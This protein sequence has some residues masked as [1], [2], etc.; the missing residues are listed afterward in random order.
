VAPDHGDLTVRV[1]PFR[2]YADFTGADPRYRDQ[3]PPLPD[4]DDCDCP[5][6]GAAAAW[7]AEK[8]PLRT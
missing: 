2:F 4:K 5:V 7:K 3:P 8:E 1:V 6:G